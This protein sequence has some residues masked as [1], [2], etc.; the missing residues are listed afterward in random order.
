MEVQE[1]NFPALGVKN[2]FFM[3]D[4]VLVESIARELGI[5]EGSYI[6]SNYPELYIGHPIIHG[7][8]SHAELPDNIRLID[9]SKSIVSITKDGDSRTI[10][11]NKFLNMCKEAGFQ[12]RLP[13][14]QLYLTPVE[15]QKLQD[16]RTFFPRKVNIGIA[17]G[18]AHRGKNWLYMRRFI[19]KMLKLEYNVFIF[20]DKITWTQHK[21]IP[22]G[23]Y[24]AIG[25][26]IREMMTYIAMMDVMVGPDTGPMHVAGAL[27][28][29]IVVVCFNVF[30][31]LY[32]MY[33]NA[34]VL[35]TTNYDPLSGIKGVSMHDVISGVQDLIGSKSSSVDVP[36]YDLTNMKPKKYAFIRMRGL[37][38]VIMSLPA[39]A[40][41]IN[42]NGN[43]RNKYTYVTSQAAKTLLKCSDL[44]TDVIGVDYDHGHSGYPLPPDGIDYSRFDTC[45]NMINAIDFVPHS[46]ERERPKLFADAIGLD[47]YD[48]ELDTWKLKVPEKWKEHAW[49]ILEGNGLR[50]SDRII[51]L[52]TNTN[53][54]SRTWQKA[55]Q[56]EF[57]GIALKHGWQVVL[58]SDKVF[59][60]YPK[61]CINLTGELSI[62]EYIGIIAIGTIG[63]SSDSA[64]VHIAGAIDQLAI[65]LYGSVDPKLRIAHYHSVHAIVGKAKCVPCNDWQMSSCSG[66]K[67]HPHCMWNITAKDVFQ[68]VLRLTKGGTDETS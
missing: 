57:C 39:I 29:P 58:V 60:K 55:R 25:N 19:T 62:E 13:H 43:A 27:N 17:L 15:W 3:G 42:N 21:T 34:R 47:T 46:G 11:P 26:P 37:G 54:L 68:Q 48:P 18:S 22:S 41:L 8:R 51:V 40:T 28:V 1:F 66:E 2:Q 33:E 20:C 45:I 24:M 53:G 14:P 49:E 52:Q 4:S 38:D 65:G 64:L 16:L 44:F 5:T 32:E 6:L 36:V 35:Q 59:T 31:E 10:I 23:C 12:S 67:H 56:V 7:V 61:R 63:V 30:A 50:R 9:L